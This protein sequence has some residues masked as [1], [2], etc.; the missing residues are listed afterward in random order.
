MSFIHHIFLSYSRRDTV[1]MQK[2][3]D[4]LRRAGFTVW[5]DEGL[6]VGTP[7]WTR[8]IDL[9]IRNTGC[10][11]VLLSPDSYQSEW[12]G[13][14]IAFAQTHKKRIFPMLVR[15]DETNAIPFQ[16]AQ[17]N[18]VDIR[19]NYDDGIARMMRDIRKH[20]NMPEMT[21]AHSVQTPS[22]KPVVMPL[23][24]APKVDKAQPKD[25]FVQPNFVQA[26]VYSQSKPIEKPIRKKFAVPRANVGGAKDKFPVFIVMSGTLGLVVLALLLASGVLGR[27]N[28]NTT[29]PTRT[30]QPT[31]INTPQ[32]TA[33]NTDLSTATNMSQPT[34][35]N[36]DLPT[37]TNIPQDGFAPITQNTNWTPIE[38]DFDGVTMVLVP[39]GC[40]M[41]GNY[42]ERPI[43]EQC[44]DTPFWIDKYE[45][46]NKQFADFGG[47]ADRNSTWTGDDLPR[48]SITW[49]EAR[50]FCALRGGRLPTEREWEYAARGP[51]NLIYPWGNEF[52]ANNVVYIGNSDRRTAPVGSHAG[53]V[54]WV[55][56]M[57]MSGNVWEW[58]SSLYA[59]YP[60]GDSS[61]N[62][63]DN[64]NNRVSRGGSWYNPSGFV[65][66]TYRSAA[67]PS[68]G[69]HG[70]DRGFRCLHS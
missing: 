12:V 29:P 25:E 65:R 8:D 32:P 5:T 39:V 21:F 69:I 9:A 36:T 10:L 35:T 50:D 31:A 30:L 22:P 60:Y 63:N 53:G 68:W 7:S 1:M 6:E 19:K 2:V 14:E 67:S 40:F 51:N 62:I 47:V 57:D 55:G 11:V 45:V 46:T 49:F 64:T 20:L 37:A 54:S 28:S 16:L 41:M 48:E 4:D 33:T 34:A 59:S 70:Y 24:P 27:N 58:V 61:E 43:H 23:K 42:D 52:I 56:A 26:Q 66:S 44:F 15:G 3:R 13:R 17:H 18:Y 38:Q